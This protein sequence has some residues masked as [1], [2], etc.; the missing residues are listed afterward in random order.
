MKSLT[1]FFFFLYNF[2]LFPWR[3]G[4][5]GGPRFFFGGE[6]AYT[7]PIRPYHRQV[8]FFRNIKKNKDES[9]IGVVKKIK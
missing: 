4:M 6:G 2:F 5:R 3:K 7:S 9:S 8:D 1:F